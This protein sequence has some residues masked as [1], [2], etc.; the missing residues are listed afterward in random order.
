VYGILTRAQAKKKREADQELFEQEFQR[1]A[2]MDNQD[3]QLVPTDGKLVNTLITNTVDKLPK[4][5]G[6]NNEDINKWLFNITN[7]LNILKLAD[8]QK[9]YTIQTLLVDDARQWYINNLS[10]IIDWST[11]VEQIQKTFSSTMHQKLALRQVGS[12]L[13]SLDETVLHY[14]NDMMSLFRTIGVNMDDQLKVAYL[15]AG[16]KV[17]LQK[18]V[19]RK[20]PETPVEFLQVAQEEEKLDASINIPVNNFSTSNMESLS[21]IK[22]SGK[23]YSQQQQHQQGQQWQSSKQIRCY[24]CNKIGHIARNCFSKNY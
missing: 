16:L 8:R 11:F 10:T 15:K 20:N 4:F 12:R 23:F 22:S 14:Y 6:T 21:A 7:E 1:L 17:S 13:Q 2:V 9:L 19:S 18:E 24:R 5:G 3:S